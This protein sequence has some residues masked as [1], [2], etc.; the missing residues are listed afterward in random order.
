MAPLLANGAR[1]VNVPHQ[2]HHVAKEHAVLQGHHREAQGVGSGPDLPVGQH[3]G[4]QVGAHLE[5]AKRE[6]A[7]QWETHAQNKGERNEL[8]DYL[9]FFNYDKSASNDRARRYNQDMITSKDR[10]PHCNN[11]YFI[12]RFLR[13]CVCMY[14]S[15]ALRKEG[16]HPGSEERALCS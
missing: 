2:G 13:V 4:P 12:L 8:A 5:C 15:K 6:S 1:Q 3:R 16:R 7:H 11:K 9:K 10:A 14:L